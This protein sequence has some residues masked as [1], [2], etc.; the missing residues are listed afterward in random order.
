M[1]KKWLVYMLSANGMPCNVEPHLTEVGANCS[2][3]NRQ[4]LHPQ[5]TYYVAFVQSRTKRVD[6][7]SYELERV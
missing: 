4:R 3:L 2:A 5:N 1:D 7:P 6:Q